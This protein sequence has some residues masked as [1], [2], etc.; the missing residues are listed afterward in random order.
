MRGR[1]GLSGS[2]RAAGAASWDHE[3]HEEHERSQALFDAGAPSS[4]F[5]FFVFF[6]VPF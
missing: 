4:A 3:K 2:V 5:V 1:A 6:V